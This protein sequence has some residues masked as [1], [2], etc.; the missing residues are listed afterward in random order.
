MFISKNILAV[1]A[2]LSGIASVAYACPGQSHTLTYSICRHISYIGIP[3]ILV[4]AAVSIGA[5]GA[6]GGG[7]LGMLLLIATPINFLLYAGLGV[8][9]QTVIR[10]C[11]KKT[12][13][14]A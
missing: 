13:H 1:A 14:S 3:G 8:G 6:H 12:D 7:P 5:L 11:K 10:M 2:L 9:V 4:A